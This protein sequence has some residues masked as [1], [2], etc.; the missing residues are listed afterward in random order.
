MSEEMRF[1]YG[2]LPPSERLAV[3]TAICALLA[4]Q[5]QERRTQWTI[6]PNTVLL[7][8]AKARGEGK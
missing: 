2:M 1:L 7:A 6:Q 5:A 3:D 8:L 4:R